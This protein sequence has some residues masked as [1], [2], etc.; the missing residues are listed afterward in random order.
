MLTWILLTFNI[1]IFSDWKNQLHWWREQIENQR[2]L[3]GFLSCS[4]WQRSFQKAVI[5]GCGKAEKQ[6]RSLR[7]NSG[8]PGIH[9]ESKVGP[10][11]TNAA[12]SEAPATTA[13]TWW[14]A[15]FGELK[16][17]PEPTSPAWNSGDTDR[18][19]NTPCCDCQE[20]LKLMKPSTCI[21][22]AV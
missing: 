17:Q 10:Q 18:K 1:S 16:P 3:S 14:E 22:Y 20:K 11:R 9:W 19:P 15:S 4:E 5:I 7:S 13:H 6:A 12:Y 8:F 2:L 21:D